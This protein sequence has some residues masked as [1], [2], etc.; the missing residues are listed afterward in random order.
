MSGKRYAF[1]FYEPP[2][3]PAGPY[4]PIRLVNPINKVSFIWNCLVDTGA[5]SCL[6]TAALAGLTGHNLTGDGVKSDVTAGIEGKQLLTYKH[7]FVLEL[8]DPQAPEMVIW[9]SRKG[10][11]ECLNHDGFP[12]LLGVT[13]FLRYFKVT[14]DY[15]HAQLTLEW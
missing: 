5:D 3:R 4:L 2:R 1:P 8:L 14:L 11:F 6:F 12:P 7:T 10:L 9:R 15:P 13:D